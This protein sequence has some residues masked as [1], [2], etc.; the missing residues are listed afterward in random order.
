MLCVFKPQSYKR[1]VTKTSCFIRVCLI[2][3]VAIVIESHYLLLTRA[4]KDLNY[5]CM[6]ASDNYNVKLFNEYIWPFIFTFIY[7]LIPS[8]LLIILNLMIIV[9]FKQSHSKVHNIHT[10]PEHSVQQTV[11][12]TSDNNHSSRKMNLSI[13]LI[14]V[15]FVSLTLPSNIHSSVNEHLIALGDEYNDIEDLN[16][17]L[18]F[19]TNATLD[20]IEVQSL[21]TSILR[22]LLVDRLLEQCMNLYHSLNFLLYILTSSLFRRE[23]LLLFKKK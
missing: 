7:S 16:N 19:H 15:S 8:I 23:F 11:I 14:C 21:R 22:V 4:P 10:A 5:N 9:R 12:D 20:Q 2:V 1:Y 13:V 6:T 3:I 18:K 17:T